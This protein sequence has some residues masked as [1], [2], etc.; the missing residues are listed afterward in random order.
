MDHEQIDF[1]SALE[2]EVTAMRGT[3]AGADLASSVPTCPGWSV[4]DLVVH[5]GGVHRHKTAIVRDQLVEELRDRPTE[6]EGD[7]LTWFGEGSDQMLAVFRGADLSAPSWTWCEHDHTAQ[8]WVRRMAHETLIHGADAVIATGG[9]LKV[10]EMLA[11]DG[12]EEILVEMMVG[13]PEWAELALGD[14]TVELVTPERSW[15]LRTA[16][17]TGESPRG[18]VYEDEPALVFVDEVDD[19]STRITGSAAD[20]D[21]WLWGRIDL[22]VD[23]VD[24]DGSLVG[25]LRS[26]AVVE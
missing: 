18:A 9:T 12:I 23:A 6:P 8:W 22:R 19:P 25:Y 24:G 4:R 11:E 13:A 20:L 15:N 5:T 2:R 10:D 26:L 7:V 16:T 21:L 17:W 3:V 14:R 1:M